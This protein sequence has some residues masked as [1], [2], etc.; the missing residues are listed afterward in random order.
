MFTSV[1]I[2]CYFSKLEITSRVVNSIAKTVVA[3]I[4][5]Q[6]FIASKWIYSSVN[7]AYNSGGIYVWQNCLM[8]FML[9]FVAAYMIENIRLFLFR[10]VIDRSADRIEHF[11]SLLVDKIKVI[12]RNFS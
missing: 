7:N 10:P 2:F 1:L 8:W 6:D 4:F 9:I 12:S 11:K 3:A 5:I